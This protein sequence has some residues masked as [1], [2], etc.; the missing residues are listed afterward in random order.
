MTGQRSLQAE[1]DPSKMHRIIEGK[2]EQASGFVGGEVGTCFAKET[3]V[4]PKRMIG[5]D[6]R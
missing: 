3:E 1:L 5:I 6:L 2:G 4:R